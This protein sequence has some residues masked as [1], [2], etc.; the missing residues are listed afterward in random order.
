VVLNIKAIARLP[1]R[2]TFVR[3]DHTVEARRVELGSIEVV[4]HQLRIADAT[5]RDAVPIP[6]RVPDG[7]HIVHAYQWDHPA[8]S[9][10]VAA[11]MA[12]GPPRLAVAR[13][14]VI[15][16]DMRPDLTAGFIVDS[17][18]ARIG[19]RSHVTFPSGLGDGYYPVIGVFNFGLFL[20]AVLVDFEVW[21]MRN[22]I[23]LPG[24][25]SDEFGIVRRADQSG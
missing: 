23:L 12:F 24:Q 25:V 16:N 17:A 7:R 21:R 1:E 18:E 19:G 9:I 11:A 3:N 13:R 2:L 20:Q 8:R 4:G 10:I 22:V 15:S 6:A 5:Y 14:L